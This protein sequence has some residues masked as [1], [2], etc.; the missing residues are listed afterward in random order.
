MMISLL[1]LSPALVPSEQSFAGGGCT[2]ASPESRL[3]QPTT[4]EFTASTPA[5]DPLAL[6]AGLVATF[7]P[8]SINSGNGS[9]VGS[10]SVR[11]YWDGGLTWR[12]RF[13]PTQPGCWVWTTSCL[14]L[15]ADRKSVV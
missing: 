14:P 11:G 8:A 1:L 2:D 4:L 5:A 7:R 15:S 9:A 13:A 10:L 3:F 6:N 12:V